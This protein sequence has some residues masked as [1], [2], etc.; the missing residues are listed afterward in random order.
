MVRW[1]FCSVP[2][3]VWARTYYGAQRASGKTHFR[4]LRGPTNRWVEILH[5]LLASGS[6]YDEAVHQRNLRSCDG[7][8]RTQPAAA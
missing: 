8:A 5:H 2:R 7:P 6:R 1:A 4:A 3:S